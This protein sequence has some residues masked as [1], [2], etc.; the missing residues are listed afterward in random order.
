MTEFVDH[1]Q[2]VFE[3]F[4]PIVLRRMFGGHGIYHKD[5][6]FALVAD[7]SLYLKVDQQSAA[8]FES[9]GLARFE[10]DKGGKR[11]QVSYFL[12]PAEIFEDP[13]EAAQWAM[14]AYAAALRSR[15]GSG[16]RRTRQRRGE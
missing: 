9:R 4:G 2:D 16:T 15:D 13:D 14:E 5:V 3:R 10:Y 1:L 8:Q 7:D 11:V 6:M 12:A